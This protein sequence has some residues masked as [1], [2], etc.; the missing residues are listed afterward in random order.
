MTATPVMSGAQNLT[1]SSG[2]RIFPIDGHC[3][4]CDNIV[5]VR[6][7]DDSVYCNRCG[8]VFTFE[9]VN[10]HMFRDDEYLWW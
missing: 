6:A 1:Y 8:A 3:P 10:G 5:W 7:S 9:P 4:D 2:D